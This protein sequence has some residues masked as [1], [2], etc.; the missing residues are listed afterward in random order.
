MS[1][2]LE[3][4]RH[5]ARTY[6]HWAILYISLFALLAVIGL[7]FASKIRTYS[8][9]SGALSLTVP[10]GRYLQG[11][12]VTF[13]LKNNF[14]APVYV[15]DNCPEEPLAVYKL[16]NSTW[17]RIHDYTSQ[18]SCSGMQ[19]QIVIPAGGQQ[20]GSFADWPNLF[21]QPGKYRIVAY[22]EYFNTM[23]YQDIEIVAT[24]KPVVQQP[25]QTQV[26]T[27]PAPTQTTPTTP[28]Y[29]T[30]YRDPYDD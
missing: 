12:A 4:T 30:P 26:I 23:T 9:P 1:M 24:P 13:T 15:A 16:V 21:S 27:S 2:E 19:R 29:T 25:V 6:L 22:V 3:Y 11:E 17:Q 5:P 14:N 10:Y 18:A 7:F 28:S 8:L 20:Q